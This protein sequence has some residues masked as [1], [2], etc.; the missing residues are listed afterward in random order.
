MNPP[1]RCIG[2][3]P[4]GVLVGELGGYSLAYDILLALVEA[5]D[6]D[7]YVLFALADARPDGWVAGLESV[8]QFLRGEAGGV[9]ST[10][11]CTPNGWCPMML[12]II[13]AFSPGM[14]EMCREDSL[15]PLFDFGE[16]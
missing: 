11:R 9:G 14:P 15:A 7:V 6:V 8:H 1:L 5:E 16:A 3:S 10:S 12:S 2:S 4:N 13:S